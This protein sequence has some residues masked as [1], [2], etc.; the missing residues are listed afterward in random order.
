MA[1][2]VVLDQ[3]RERVL[4]LRTSNSRLQRHLRRMRA[5][6][7]PEFEVQVTRGQYQSASAGLDSKV[8]TL[9]CLPVGVTLFVAFILM[10]S[11]FAVDD[12]SPAAVTENGVE[13]VQTVNAE[14]EESG[15]AT[16]LLWFIAIF[17]SLPFGIAA[18]PLGAIL[19]SRTAPKPIWLLRIDKDGRMTARAYI[20][21]YVR[22]MLTPRYI[23]DY[24]DQ[25]SLRAMLKV[26]RS[27]NTKLVYGAMIAGVLV[28]I[29]AAYV[30]LNNTWT[31]G[32]PDVR[33]TQTTIVTTGD[34]EAQPDAMSNPT[35]D[36]LVLTPVASTE[37]KR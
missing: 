13:V 26:K 3:R 12:D 11:L 5:A 18:F 21:E 34:S 36:G 1:E 24:A 22:G 2:C 4:Q 27:Q 19:A 35:Q 23:A 9:V 10:R 8:A 28:S 14:G 17:V 32:T 7:D 37:E 6:E 29:F 15:G 25:P 33:S 16:R 30:F 20:M 31:D